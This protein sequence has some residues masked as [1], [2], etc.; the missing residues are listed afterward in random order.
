MRVLLAMSGGVDS[1][2]CAHLLKEEG[3]DVIGIR[4]TLWSDPAAPALAKILTGKCCDPQS[5]ARSKKVCKDLNIPLHIYDLKDDF[6][7][8]IVDPFLR[9]YKEGITP[10]PCISCNKI[11]K[12]GRLLKIADDLECDMLATGHYARVG[13]RKDKEG[14]DYYALLQAKDY[15]KDQSYYLYGLSQPQLSRVIFPLGSRLKKDVYKLADKY[16]VPYEKESYKESQDLCFFPEKEPTEFLI[17]YLKDGLKEGNIKTRDGKVIGKHKGLPFYTIG[18]RRM[19]IG[20][21]PIPLEVVQ[22]ISTDNTIIV[23]PKGKETCTI[24]IVKDLN[25]IAGQPEKGEIL[26]CRPRSLSPKYKVSVVINGKSATIYFAESI[27]LQ[28][29]GQSAVFYRADE[30]VGGGVIAN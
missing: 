17:R 20:G 9:G 10:N 12:F 4:F 14:S 16:N 22:K 19:G 24:I 26:D 28:A 15:C 3:N 8:N 6:K 18:Q 5:A 7:K 23:A 30:I 29:P 1:S 2:V 11:I 25:W 21:Q 13:K 27:P